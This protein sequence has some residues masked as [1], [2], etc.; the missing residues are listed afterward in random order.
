[1]VDGAFYRKRAFYFWGDVTP[2]KRAEELALYCHKHIKD[3][4]A[5]A[6]LYRV[7]YYDCLPSNKKIYHPLLKK[8]I[9]LGKS[10]QYQRLIGINPTDT[11]RHC[12]NCG[13][14]VDPAWKF[15]HFCGNKLF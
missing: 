2:A 1:M 13:N 15:C 4:R 5:G 12:P 11:A 10:E 3:E 14:A 8:T 9:D 6:E 7:F